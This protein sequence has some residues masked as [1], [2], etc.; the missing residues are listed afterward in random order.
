MGRQIVNG[1]KERPSRNLFMRKFSE[2]LVGAHNLFFQ[3]QKKGKLWEGREVMGGRI[4][5]LSV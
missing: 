2:I 4:V 3:A 5:A 1:H